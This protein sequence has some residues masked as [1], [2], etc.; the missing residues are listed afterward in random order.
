MCIIHSVYLCVTVR[1]N[2][3]LVVLILAKNSIRFVLAGQSLRNN[4][5]FI[6]SCFKCVLM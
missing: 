1:I 5:T 3:Y 6:V 4:S 2:K